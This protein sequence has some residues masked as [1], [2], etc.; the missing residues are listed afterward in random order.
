MRPLPVDLDDERV[1]VARIRAGS[2]DAFAR[3]FRD[4][5]VNLVGYAESFLGSHEDAEEIVCDLFSHLYDRRGEWDPGG[6]VRGYLFRA[7]RNRVFNFVRDTRRADARMTAMRQDDAEGGYTD[8]ADVAF[9][10]SE[11][12]AVRAAALERVMAELPARAREV[13]ALRWGEG[14]PDETIAEI[15]E[16]TV[17]AVRMQASR[18]L[19]VLRERLPRYLR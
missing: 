7:A 13:V 8:P 17:A 9:L 14:M 2:E 11:D 19:K 12:A 3:L 4:H 6:S 1:L 15:L 18:A 16:T 10:A 5:Y